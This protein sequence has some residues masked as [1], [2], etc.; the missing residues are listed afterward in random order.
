[1]S[2]PRGR[3]RTAPPWQAVT[4][5]AYRLDE[6]ISSVQKAVRRCDTDAALFWAVE[7]NESGYGAY[8]WRRLLVIASEDVGLADPMAAV[9]VSALYANAV[10]LKKVRPPSDVRWDGL[11]LLQATAYLARA[12]KNREVPDCYSTIELRLSRGE[13]PEIPD[14]A[15]DGHTARGRA[16]GRAEGFFQAEGRRVENLVEVDGNPWAQ[17][18]QRE[19][20]V[21]KDEL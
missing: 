5:H 21:A 13:R 12:S 4:A 1:M 2:E 14:H 16:Q 18:W 3:S 15:I 6:V 10:A 19:R 9:V 17:R 20:P 11:T 8:A 7:L